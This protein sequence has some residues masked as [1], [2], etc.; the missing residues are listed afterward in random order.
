[1]DDLFV[2]CYFDV[3]GAPGGE[4]AA[5]GVPGSPV[6]SV[7]AGNA[8]AAG[9]GGGD[10][11]RSADDAALDDDKEGGTKE[12]TAKQK[13]ERRERNSEHAKR[14]RLRKKFLIESLQEQIH[15]LQE[16]MENMK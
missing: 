16:Q 5:G 10:R 9:V 2:D 8:A 6:P 14:S 3:P 15:A 1:M 12:L 4:A 13:L 11:K 7:S